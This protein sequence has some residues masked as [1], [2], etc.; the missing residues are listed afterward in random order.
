M[1]EV[2]MKKAVPVKCFYN[3]FQTLTEHDPMSANGA[4]AVIGEEK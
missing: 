2:V 3:K 4:K 1:G